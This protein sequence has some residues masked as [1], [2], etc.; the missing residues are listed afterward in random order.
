VNLWRTLA[1][2]LRRQF[3]LEVSK[4]AEPTRFQLFR[5][6]A[7]PR[8][9]PVLLAR[10]AH[11]AH[12]CH[13]RPLAKLYA[14]TNYVLFGIEIAQRCDIG[15]GLYFP[16]TVG[17]VIGAARIGRNAV[18]YHGVTLGAKE[19][20]LEYRESGRPSLGDDVTIASGAKVIGGVKIGDGATVA[21][22]AVVTKDVAAG[23]LVGGIPASPIKSVRDA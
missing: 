17:T 9:T 22:N 19:L 12:R 1:A 20:D 18:I 3:Y 14:L 16:H 7:N 13:L 23:Q 15:P 8:F 6:I 5:R 21:A 11:S 4:E 10:L 2:D